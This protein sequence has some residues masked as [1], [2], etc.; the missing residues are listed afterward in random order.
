[1]DTFDSPRRAYLRLPFKVPLRMRVWKAGTSEHYLESEN[2][3]ARGTFFTIPFP[4]QTGSALEIVLRMPQEV[5]G[6]PSAD[7]RCT[8]RVVRVEPV[9]DDPG[10]FGIGVQ[11]DCYEILDSKRHDR[12][13][14]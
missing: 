14:D 2:L 8:G 4:L 5:T 3:S 10:K 13:E 6:R 1:M 11:F 12:T 7:W 9:D